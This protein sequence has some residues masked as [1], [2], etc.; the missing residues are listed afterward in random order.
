M[1]FINLDKLN[2]DD[3]E[4]QLAGK[5]WVIPGSTPVKIM[6]DIVKSSQR[7]A[8]NPNDVEATENALRA[9]WE[10]FKIRN[11]ELTFDDFSKMITIE[12]Y[13]ALVN[14]IYGGLTPEQTKAEIEKE[15]NSNIEKKN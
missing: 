10:V 4:I 15:I 12:Q 5:K 13:I 11:S 9:M 2:P 1:K 3:K 7:L 14:F 6:L 8:D